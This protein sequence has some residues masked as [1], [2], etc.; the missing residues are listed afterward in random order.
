M[1]ER[2]DLYGAYRQFSDPVLAAIRH[3]TFG[4]DIGQNSWTTVDEYARILPWLEVPA[5]GNVL[6]VAS[7]SGGPAIHLART[8]GCRVTGIDHDPGGVATATR[9]ASE[10]DMSD[11][12]QFQGAD[13]NARLPFADGAFDAVICIDAMNHLRERAA[14]LGEWRRVLRTGGRALFTDPVVV[15]GP[16]TAEELQLRSSIGPFLFVP[17][18]LNERIIDGAGLR[19][20]RRED[21]SEEAAQVAGRWHDAREAH[22][23][24]L[25]K[26]EGDQRFVGLQSFFAAVRDL[27]RERRLSRILYLV[28]KPAR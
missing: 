3:Q 9:A 24:A 10:A 25:V 8:L 19:L 14:V 7:G 20:V 1:T 12:V 16:V 26:M 6:E 2:V 15:T 17:D 11:R 23:D 13:A 4:I 18:G 5:D 21:T 27:T 28:E 22:R